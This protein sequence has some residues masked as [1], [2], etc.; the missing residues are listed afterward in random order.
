MSEPRPPA[1]FTSRFFAYSVLTRADVVALS[2][3]YMPPPIPL[4]YTVE[5]IVHSLRPDASMLGEWPKFSSEYFKK[6]DGIGPAA[7]LDELATIAE[8]HDHR[9]L[10]LLS[11][12]DTRAPHKSHRPVLQLWFEKRTGF[13][14][15]ELTNDG[16]MLHHLQLHRHVQPIL[17]EVT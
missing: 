13:W 8:K 12:E 2:I 15:P 14:L 3:S 4:P 1:T 11:L 16:E 5:G 9:P 7:I 17:P 6:L 10:A